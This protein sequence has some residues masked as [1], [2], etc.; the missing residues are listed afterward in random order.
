MLS[1]RQ[2]TLRSAAVAALAGLALVQVVEF[3][4]TV[5]QARHL[6]VLSGL[7]AALCVALAAALAAARPASGG[8]AWRA[9]GALGALVLGGWVA[10]RLVAIPGSATGTG[11]WTT[12]PGLASGGLGLACAG[13]AL[14]GGGGVRPA[15]AAAAAIARGCAVVAALVPAAGMLVVALGPGPSGGER[16]IAGVAGAHAHVHEA[17]SAGFRPG[18]GGHAGH[19]IYPN[20]TP[21]HLP[22]WA[23]ALAVGAAALLAYVAAS[24]LRRRATPVAATAARSVATGTAPRALATVLLLLVVFAGVTSKASAHA[25]LLR[26]V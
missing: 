5:A 14:A 12:A 9:V 4:Y 18:F 7:L 8:A 11:N 15:R 21:P 24:A 2:A 22:A 13:L 23:L 19:Y 16:A 3:P 1:A 20:A 10:T 17:A 6:A 26:S 25:T